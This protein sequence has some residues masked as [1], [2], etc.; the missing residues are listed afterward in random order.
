MLFTIPNHVGFVDALAAGLLA[1][2][3]DPQQLARTLVLLPNR[4]AVRALTEAFVRHCAGG[5]LLL[6][7]LVPVGDLDEDS[8]DRLAAGDLLLPPA[9]SAL[10]RRL[11]LGRLVRQRL[12]GA[13]P[14]RSAVEGLRLGSALADALDTL[15]AEEIPPEQLREAVADADMAH[16]WQETLAFLDIIITAWPPE[17]DRLGASDGGTRL[18][19]AIDALIARWQAAPPATPVIAAGITSA[20]PAIGRLLA[21]VLA[22]PQGQVILPGLDTNLSEAGTARWEAIIATPTEGVAESEA[23]PHHALKR[24]LAR[25]GWARDEVRLWPHALPDPLLARR[26]EEVIAAFAPADAGEG[27]AEPPADAD[28]A[29]AAF[30]AVR[31]VEADTPAEEAQALALALREALETPGRTAALVTPDR[32]LARR[33]AAH[34]RRWGIAVDDSAGQP[35]ARTPPG[36]LALALVAALAEHFAPVALLALLKHPLVRRGEDRLAWLDHVRQLDL[37]LRGVRPAPG[38]DGIAAHVDAWLNEKRREDEGLA[39]WWAEVS[40]LLAPLE[41]EA[42][43]TDLARLALAL[44][45]VAEALAGEA[46][47]AGPDGRALAARLEALGLEGSVFGGFGSDEAPALLAALF[48]DIAIRPAWGG[49]PRLSI[50]GPVEAQLMRADLMIL[51]GLN[52]GSWPAPLSPDPWLAPA[53]RARLGLP[54]QAR[55]IGTAAADFIRALGAPQVLVSRARRD[56][57]GPMLPS[58][59]MARLDAHV[60][61][62]SDAGLIRETR[63]VRIARGLDAEQPPRPSARPAPC[64]PPELRPRS[65]SVTEVDTL[66]AD[67][68]A[69]YAARMLRLKPLDPLDADPGAADRGK[70]LHGVLEDWIKSGSLDPARL[71]GLGEAMLLRACGGFPLLAALWG[72]RARRALDWAGQELLAR[73]AAGW[74]PLAAE[75]RGEITLDNGITLKGRADRIDRDDTGRLAI[76]DYKTGAPPGP[77]QVREGLSNQLPLLAVIAGEGAFH[78]GSRRLPAGPVEMLEYWRLSGGETPGVAR[79]ALGKKDKPPPVPDHVSDTRDVVTSIL[80]RMLLRP[81]P[82]VAQLHPALSWPDYDHLARVQEWRNLPPDNG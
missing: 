22:L 17:R 81:T 15:L 45:S 30:A 66:I 3:D 43:T 25:L 11:E 73:V 82:F 71:A 16:H 42:G 69:F 12:A 32:A 52:E 36:S 76:I 63:L 72:P 6:P 18:T 29:R 49:H 10:T 47:W 56:A 4:R 79:P 35:L 53:I 48:A 61:R 14:S 40:A 67:P 1:R 7:R 2:G 8:F 28:A 50:L 39:D 55:A 54:G 77:Q 74:Q 21:A 24:L 44:Q 38:L 26:E 78:E 46:A 59:F 58:R 68:F 31:V 62:F 57:G 70:L 23:H 5:G 33:V 34:C 75:A 80:T 27:W 37:V 64:P 65:L 41:A 20:T 9:V 19:A 51:A 13:Q 60:A